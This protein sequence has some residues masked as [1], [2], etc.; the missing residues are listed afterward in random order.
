MTKHSQ[1]IVNVIIGISTA[2]GLLALL[3]ALFLLP[4][5]LF[6]MVYEVPQMIIHLQAWLSREF[7]LSNHLLEWGPVF[8]L[9]IQ[10]G[11]FLSL[12]YTMNRVLKIKEPGLHGLGLPDESDKLDSESQEDE[13]AHHVSPGILLSFILIFLVLLYLGVSPYFG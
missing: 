13:D 11:L 10:S 9:L 12:A 3:L 6:G 5:A 1:I 4:R 8:M 2:C 7:D